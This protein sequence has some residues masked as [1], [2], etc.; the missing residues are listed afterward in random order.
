M[1][2]AKL[3]RDLSHELQECAS[4]FFTESI[5]ELGPRCAEESVVDLIEGPLGEYDHR[6]DVGVFDYDADALDYVASALFSSEVRHD[7]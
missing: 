3:S 4:F 1:S 6:L 2:T 7:E 5:D